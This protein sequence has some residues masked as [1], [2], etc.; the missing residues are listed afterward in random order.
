M[1]GYEVQRSNLVEPPAGWKFRWLTRFVAGE[2][3]IEPV[4]STL[5]LRI[6]TDARD[7]MEASKEEE[8][9]G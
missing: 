6:S 3:G 2:G 8:G 7:A 1:Q 9:D 5:E 4:Y